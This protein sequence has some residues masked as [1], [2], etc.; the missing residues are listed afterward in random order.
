MS[1]QSLIS[2][3][4]NRFEEMQADI[5]FKENSPTEARVEP[6][7]DFFPTVIMLD[8]HPI[9]S[10]LVVEIPLGP[11]TSIDLNVEEILKINTQLDGYLAIGKSD[12]QKLLAHRI[13]LTTNQNLEIKP[14]IFHHTFSHFLDSFY[15]IYEKFFQDGKNQDH[16]PPGDI[17]RKKDPSD[18]PEPIGFNA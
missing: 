12:S 7:G 5:E 13:S 1:K 11:L 8:L 6:T 15:R 16:Q 9:E 4:E 18:Q 14:I 17:N 3:F 10:R 2:S